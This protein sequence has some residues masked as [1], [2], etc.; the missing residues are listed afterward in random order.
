M[1]TQ[2]E[3][4]HNNHEQFTFLLEKNKV[5]P[6]V[7]IEPNYADQRIKIQSSQ[8]LQLKTKKMKNPKSKTIFQRR[9]DRKKPKTKN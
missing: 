7:Q 1:E 5:P 2:R 6:R 8:D 4:K 9:E 3:S